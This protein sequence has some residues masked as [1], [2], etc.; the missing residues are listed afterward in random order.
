MTTSWTPNIDESLEN[1]AS[2]IYFV[3]ILATW[4]YRERK[5]HFNNSIMNEMSN[6]VHV[7][8]DVFVA[9]M[10]NWVFGELDETLIVAPK[11]S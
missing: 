7:Y 10:L 5:E 1:F 2:I 9:L 3:K 8:L 6:E 4:T 11:A